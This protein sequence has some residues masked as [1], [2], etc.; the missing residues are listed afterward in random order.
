[1]IKTLL[2]SVTAL[3]FV[4]AVASP[5]TVEAKPE[6]TQICHFAKH[7]NDRILVDEADADACVEQGGKVLSVGGKAATRGHKIGG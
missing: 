7:E 6:K 5:A 2:A 1:M 3:A 4:L